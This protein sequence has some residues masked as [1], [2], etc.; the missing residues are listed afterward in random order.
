VYRLLIG[1]LNPG[2]GAAVVRRVK[3]NGFPDA[4]IKTSPL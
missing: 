4:F 1:P 2:E 3:S